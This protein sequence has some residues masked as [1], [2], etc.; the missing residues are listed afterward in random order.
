M[1]LFLL[2]SLMAPANQAARSDLVR[3]RLNAYEQLKL[4]EPDPVRLGPIAT[5]ALTQAAA[6]S[7]FDVLSQACA[8]AFL[9]ERRACAQQLRA[10]LAQPARPLKTR[11]AAASALVRIGDKDAVPQLISLTK[12][13][14]PRELSSIVPE[15]L[16]LPEEPLLPLLKRLAASSDDDA[17]VVSCRALATFDSTAVRQV[18]ADTTAAMAPGS[19]PWLAC[20]V[21]RGRLGEPDAV[22]KLAGISA[23]V[24]GQDLIDAGDAMIAAGKDGGIE[25]LRKAA[26]TGG[27]AIQL[28]AAERLVAVDR[29]AAIELSEPM[30]QAPDPKLRAA[31]LKVERRLQRA[32][33]ARV[34]A[35]LADSD[36]RVRLRAAEAILAWSTRVRG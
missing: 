3:E 28:E 36:A 23:H 11:A 20:T 31:A 35:L 17:Q 34:R 26:R 7:D 9:A 12:S 32:P 13:L 25:T 6:A 21:A 5:L 33:S 27:A 18:L 16:A 29:D 8:S 2:L 30:L 19:R 10:V 22:W 24:R 14:S 15:L 4:T 1:I